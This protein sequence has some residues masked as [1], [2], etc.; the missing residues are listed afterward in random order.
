MALRMSCRYGALTNQV[1]PTQVVDMAVMALP[2]SSGNG[3]GLLRFQRPLS[4]L[5]LSDDSFILSGDSRFTLI[6]S[7]T[8][9]L[10][11]VEDSSCLSD[12]LSVV[13]VVF[14]GETALSDYLL[15]LDSGVLVLFLEATVFLSCG[16]LTGLLLLP[17]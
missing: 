8:L 16:V 12:L 4:L 9:L 17:G 7:T 11:L 5:L 6:G 13:F 10:P 3:I 1:S 14:L 2:S 15:F